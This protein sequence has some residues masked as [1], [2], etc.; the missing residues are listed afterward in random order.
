MQL[1]KFKKFLEKQ[2]ESPEDEDYVEDDGDFDEDY[3]N[4]DDYLFGGQS[5]SKEESKETP[6]EVNDGMEN[7][8]DLIRDMFHLV[9]IESSCDYKGLDITV[10]VGMNYRDK[11][12][13]L[14]KVLGI[15]QKLKKDVL[16]DYDSE[17]ELW[18]D[19]KGKPLL[20][21]Y[22]YSTGEAPF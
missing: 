18:K 2:Y 22:F 13:N 11:L 15:A 3:Y 7:V 19:K 9:G 20:I 8:C 17:F 21:F 5:H 6:E 10:Y 16:V 14:T 4:S 1:D 12:K